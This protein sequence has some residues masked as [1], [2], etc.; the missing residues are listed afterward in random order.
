LVALNVADKVVAELGV[1]EIS[2]VDALSV[3]GL[4]LP[5]TIDHVIGAVP[6]L[7]RV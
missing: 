3:R 1:P 6:V 2:P 4:I 5:E 7:V